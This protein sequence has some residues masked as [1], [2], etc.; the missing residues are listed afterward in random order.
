MAQKVQVTLIDDYDGG[1]ADETVTF[2][3][4]G[5]NYEIDL[6]ANNAGVLRDILGDYVRAGRKVSTAAKAGRK[7]S[8]AAKVSAGTV[9][10]DREQ[11]AAMREWGRRN[12]YDLKE[13]GRIP[14]EV[15][16]AYQ[17]SAGRDQTVYAKM[18]QPA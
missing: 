15:V 13:R 14:R 2:A 12:G 11:M 6:S 3:V 10:A 18:L 16:D 17:A 4:D 7:T 8:L 9:R 1:T 5:T